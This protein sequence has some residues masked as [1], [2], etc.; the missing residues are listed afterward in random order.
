MSGPTGLPTL[1]PDDASIVID[2]P[3]VGPGFWAG[4]PSAVRASDGTIWLAY[5]LRRPHGDGRGYANMA[6]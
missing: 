6:N 2:P 1:S 5:R 3:G 4:G